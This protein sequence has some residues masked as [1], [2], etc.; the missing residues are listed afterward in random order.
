MKRVCAAVEV[1]RTVEV[2][3]EKFL[4]VKTY[5][6]GHKGHC[7]QVHIIAQSYF[8]CNPTQPY[9]NNVITPRPQFLTH[10]FSMSILTP[11]HSSIQPCD[12]AH[13]FIHAILPLSS[14]SMSSVSLYHSQ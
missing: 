8:I 10:P 13:L 1:L 6:K 12:V 9:A 2:I 5:L 14:S 7:L 11:H 3:F 4:F